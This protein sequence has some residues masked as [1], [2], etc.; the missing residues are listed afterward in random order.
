MSFCVIV[1][2]WRDVL[3]FTPCQATLSGVQRNRPEERVSLTPPFETMASS[4]K[5]G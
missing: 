1:R 2:T 4:S 5:A 3:T